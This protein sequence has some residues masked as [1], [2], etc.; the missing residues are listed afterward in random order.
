MKFRNNFYDLRKTKRK[1]KPKD[2]PNIGFL[3]ELDEKKLVNSWL[4]LRD[5]SYNEKTHFTLRSVEP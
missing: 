4:V 1:K 3:Y 5:S 2:E